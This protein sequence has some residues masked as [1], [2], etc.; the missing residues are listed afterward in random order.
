RPSQEA[1][2]EAVALLADAKRPVIM[3][4][5]GSRKAEFWA[6]RIK[7][8]ERLGACV[9]TDL[10]QGA[11]FPTDHPAHYTPPFNV[12][13]QDARA[14]LCEADV[15]LALD[16]MDLGGALRQ[17]KSIGKVTGRII[18]CSMDQN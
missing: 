9:V 2:D 3:Y 15:I 6:P 4:G 5:R 17:A 11:M 13:G 16:W 10:K 14:L 8:A 18:A 12:L 1:V 7:L